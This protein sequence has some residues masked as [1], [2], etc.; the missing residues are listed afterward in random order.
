MLQ[1]PDFFLGW[2][3]LVLILIFL[4]GLRM[5]LPLERRATLRFP[6]FCLLVLVGLEILTLGVSLLTTFTSLVTTLEGLAL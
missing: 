3:T 4:V 6:F 2:L 5:L 1:Q